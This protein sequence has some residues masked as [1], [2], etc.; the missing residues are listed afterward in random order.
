MDFHRHDA[1]PRHWQEALGPQRL[2]DDRD[3]LRGE[4]RQQRVKPTP[5]DDHI[6]LVFDSHEEDGDWVEGEG[7]LQRLLP[8]RNDLVNG[9]LRSLYLGWLA[10]WPGG[11]L[12]DDGP[13]LRAAMHDVEAGAGAPQCRDRFSRRSRGRFQPSAS[14]APCSTTTGFRD[15]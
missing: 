12:G 4:I 2:L 1:R 13:L 11:E 15:P 10:Q 8:L 14:A 9:D 5:G 3:D 7:W 6:V